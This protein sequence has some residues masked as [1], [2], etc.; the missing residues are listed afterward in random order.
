MSQLGAE[1][2]GKQG[3]RPPPRH[4]KYTNAERLRT[5]KSIIIHEKKK[6]QCEIQC[7]MQLQHKFV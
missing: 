6:G 7:T 4:F 5:A 2:G 1:A 3:P